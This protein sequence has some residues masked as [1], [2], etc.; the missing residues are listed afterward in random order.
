M[1]IYYYLP[2]LI[3]FFHFISLMM[4]NK[5]KAILFIILSVIFFLI[6]GFRE[7]GFDYDM[8]NYLFDVYEKKDWYAQSFNYSTEIGYAFT[9]HIS[10]SFF[11]LVAMISGVII[12][13]QFYF[14]YKNTKYPFLALFVYFGIFFY[15]SLMGQ[16]R[17]AFSLGLMLIAINNIENR[18]KFLFLIFIAISFHYTAIFT[19]V[20]LW[21]P[22]NLYKFRTYILVLI[23]S[24]IL[25]FVFP[26][27]FGKISSLTSYL[28]AKSSFY[29]KADYEKI[30]GI[31]SV[32]LI[33]F[34]LFCLCFF[35]RKEFVKLPKMEFFMNIYFLSLVFYI[36]FSFM[37]ALASRG[38]LYFAFFEVILVSNLLYVLRKNI[39]IYLLVFLL[40]ITMSISR[41]INSF[42]EDNFQEYFVPYRNWLIRSL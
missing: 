8:Y 3:L 41:Q 1:D 7:I 33:R 24:V 14:I 18:K 19:L 26:V 9:N 22:K 16:Y 28:E 40:S 13:T 23:G 2:A 31:N 30:S 21:L 20:L 6:V 15:T 29:E 25:A 37:T 5:L 12:T 38:S 10:P 42:N 39:L 32:M 17:Q 4:G 35:F 27:A 34:T 11:F 36:A